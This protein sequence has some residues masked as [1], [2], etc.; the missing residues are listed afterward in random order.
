MKSKV[1]NASHPG[2]GVDAR[3]L[4]ISYRWCEF[5]CTESV[6]GRDRLDAFQ[7]ASDAFKAPSLLILPRPA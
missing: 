6:F 2:P 3:V 5:G 1:L 4:M 7:V